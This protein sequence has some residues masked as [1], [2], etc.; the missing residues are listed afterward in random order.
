MIDRPLMMRL[1]ENS[2]M[3]V[4]LSNLLGC[5]SCE[6]NDRGPARP[7]PLESV[8]CDKFEYS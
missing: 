5:V 4:F 7:I 1:L 8:T 2:S 6:F 3:T